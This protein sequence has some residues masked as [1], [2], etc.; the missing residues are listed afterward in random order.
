MIFTGIWFY[1]L[2]E[3]EPYDAIIVS[4]DAAFNFAVDNKDTLFKDIPIFFEGVNNDDKG[5][6]SLSI[7]TD[8]RCH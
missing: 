4:D 7:I 3:V 8:Y 2:G 5:I 6:C 1:Y